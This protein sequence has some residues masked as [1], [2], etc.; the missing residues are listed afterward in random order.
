MNKESQKKNWKTFLFY[1][2]KREFPIVC[3]TDNAKKV[4][5]SPG[6][7]CI[8]EFTQGKPVTSIKQVQG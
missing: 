5:N 1:A 3:M 2:R 8:T 4:C 6:P 7:E